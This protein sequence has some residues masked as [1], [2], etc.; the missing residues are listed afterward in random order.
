VPG[1]VVPSGMTTRR[2]VIL[3]V[4]A[5][6]VLLIILAAVWTLT[7]QGKGAPVTASKP[8]SS[9]APSGGTSAGGA[10]SPSANAASPAQGAPQRLGAVTL[11]DVLTGQEAIEDMSMLHGKDVGVVG[12]WVGHYQARGIA[13]V[14]EIVDEKG[15]VQLLDSMVARI[16]VGNRVFTGLKSTQIDGQKLY[17]VTGQGQN[18]YFYQKGSKV[19]WLSLPTNKPDDFLRDGLKLIS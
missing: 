10:S 16:G 7:G 5:A 8:S 18:H 19:I 13:F 2:K 14:G 12:G 15:A 4:Q 6:L 3:S 17:F 9:A 1:A 11:I